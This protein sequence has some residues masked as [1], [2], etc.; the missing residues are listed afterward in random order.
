[1]AGLRGLALAAAT[2]GLLCCHA[3]G[4]APAAKYADCDRAA[5]DAPTLSHKVFPTATFAIVDQ[6]FGSEGDTP[7]RQKVG[8]ERVR[9]SDAV[10]LTVVQSGCEDYAVS[11]E[12]RLTEPV[13]AKADQ[14]Y[15][16]ERA[17]QLIAQVEPGNRNPVVRLK[18]LRDAL[19]RRAA[20]SRGRP[21]AP[22]QMIEERLDNNELGTGYD[23]TL[24]RT[25][26][27]AILTVAYW[28]EL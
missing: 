26:S 21:L 8:R 6:T 15:W 9:L 7:L 25:R 20:R 5:P 4:A 12:F 18:R 24:K 2:S 22:E 28:E 27:A 14:A 19:H 10:E 23:L 16:L 17:A 13:P 1:M 3:A 11:Y